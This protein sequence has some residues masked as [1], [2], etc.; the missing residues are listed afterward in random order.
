MTKI[1]IPLYYQT[2]SEIELAEK[3]YHDPRIIAALY[4]DDAQ[5][6]INAIDQ[7]L[8][9]TEY[10]PNIILEDLLSDDVWGMV[11]VQDI[12][13]ITGEACNPTQEIDANDL[14][15][16][17]LT[18][19]WL[20]NPTDRVQTVALDRLWRKFVT[21]CKRMKK[22]DDLEVWMAPKAPLVTDEDLNRLFN[23]N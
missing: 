22:N 10:N 6:F 8:Y 20:D 13:T 3:A 17:G 14:K 5:G 7:R 19:L 18:M 21:K 15:K 1:N 4:D 23:K 9:D 12:E 2:D 16:V 11:K